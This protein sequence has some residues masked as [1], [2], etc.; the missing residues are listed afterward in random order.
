MTLEPLDDKRRRLRAAAPYLLVT[1][2]G[3]GAANS[4]AWL[5]MHDAVHLVAVGAACIVLVLGWLASR[6]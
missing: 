1:G 6:I 4:T 5:L 2:I 3:A